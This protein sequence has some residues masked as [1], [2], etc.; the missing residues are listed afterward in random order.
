M[1]HRA[2][3]NSTMTFGRGGAQ[4]FIGHESTIQIAPYWAT[5]VIDV[6]GSKYIFSV[7]HSSP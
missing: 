7:S 2:A 4:P 3:I 5:G 1:R 6:F